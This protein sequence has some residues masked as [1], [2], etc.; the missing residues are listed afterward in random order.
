MCNVHQNLYYLLKM[1]KLMILSEF[2]ENYLVL[3]NN[4]LKI[5]VTKMTD[6]R[7]YNLTT[8]EMIEHDS[9]KDIKLLLEKRSNLYNAINI[10]C[11]LIAFLTSKI[12]MDSFDQSDRDQMELLTKNFQQAHL[13]VDPT[14]QQLLTSP[15]IDPTN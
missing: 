1:K 4:I 13:K 2:F 3:V 14:I 10:S 7:C 15:P 5:T 9:N 8:E 11:K 12:N 6:H